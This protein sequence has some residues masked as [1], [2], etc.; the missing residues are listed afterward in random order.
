MENVVGVDYVAVKGLYFDWLMTPPKVRVPENKG[1][2][3]EKYAVS[4]QSLYAWEKHPEFS[5]RLVDE[6]Q[7][8]G[9]NNYAMVIGEILG[10]VADAETAPQNKVNAARLLFDVLDMKPKPDAKVEA[11]LQ[12]SDADKAELL[13]ALSDATDG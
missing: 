4:R 8:L 9:V 6:R 7:R 3:A 11:R 2:F 5:K 12:L 10:I 13:K 1:L